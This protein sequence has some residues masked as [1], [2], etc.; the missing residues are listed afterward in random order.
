[1]KTL[2]AAVFGLAVFALAGHARADDTAKLLGKWEIT[3]S[4]GDSPVGAIV[5]FAKEGKMTV[6]INNDGKD[7]KLEGTYKLDGK[8]LAVKLTLNEQEIKHDLTVTFK[9]DDGLELEDADKKVDTLKK[10]K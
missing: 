9:G 8:K 7:L 5:E 6:T 3:K 1:M 2:L 4:T 10:K